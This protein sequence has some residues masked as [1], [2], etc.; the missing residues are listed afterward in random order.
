MPHVHSRAGFEAE[1]LT[2]ITHSRAA[3]AAA[4]A[5]VTQAKFLRRLSAGP[6]S[7]AVGASRRESRAAAS[8]ADLRLCSL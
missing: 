6:A 5:D 1:P 2:G 4:A 8:R 7:N 3:A